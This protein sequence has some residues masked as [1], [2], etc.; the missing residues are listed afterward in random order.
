[1][2]M[3]QVTCTENALLTLQMPFSISACTNDVSDWTLYVT[4]GGHVPRRMGAATGTCKNLIGRWVQSCLHTRDSNAR[5]VKAEGSFNE[6]QM[7]A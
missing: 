5:F 6:H 3:R 4:V 2:R 7:L 1:M